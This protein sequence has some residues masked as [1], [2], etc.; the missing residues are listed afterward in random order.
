M[1]LLGY[2]MGFQ[3]LVKSH[4]SVA[5]PKQSDLASAETSIDAVQLP[6]VNDSVECKESVDTRSGHYPFNVL[7]YQPR[8]IVNTLQFFSTMATGVASVMHPRLG[9]E[10][11]MLGFSKL[12]TLLT[13]VQSS[14]GYRIV[15][16][17]KKSFPFKPKEDF[18]DTET[19]THV[20]DMPTLPS[21][22]SLS[23]PKPVIYSNQAVQL[24]PQLT[25]VVDN[26][27]ATSYDQSGGSSD[28]AIAISFGTPTL[29]HIPVVHLPEQAELMQA[30][31]K[32]KTISVLG[33]QPPSLSLSRQLPETNAQ[34]RQSLP[35]P[36]I[37]SN[38]GIQIRS[39][40]SKTIIDNSV[41]TSSYTSED[42]ATATFLKSPSLLP[43]S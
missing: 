41:V 1:T 39:P 9:R 37:Y 24:S 20:F 19:F 5:E 22:L 40:E 23:I 30:K 21:D 10:H 33:K 4:I 43:I 38:Q 2:S 32:E 26:S 3:G 29:L 31:P 36:V 12:L 18:P 34:S 7:E 8:A 35:K 17:D 15:E 42:S 25:T 11:S 14:D 16:A 28:S 13:T 6:C 27:Q